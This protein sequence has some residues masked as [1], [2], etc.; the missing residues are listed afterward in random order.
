M[1][2]VG[3]VAIEAV[4]GEDGADVLV[5]ADFFGRGGGA[6]SGIQDAS[7]QDCNQR[8]AEGL[9]IHGRIACYDN[10]PCYQ[11]F[12]GYVQLL[13]WPPRHKNEN[14][15]FRHNPN[16]LWPTSVADWLVI[17]LLVLS[18]LALLLP[19]AAGL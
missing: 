4:A 16:A 6:Q 2:G 11:T 1:L 8:V 5:E 7:G 14:M 19:A 9:T 18:A 12:F 13:T 17:V 3:S 15:R 10:P